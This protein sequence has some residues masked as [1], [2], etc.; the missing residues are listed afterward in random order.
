M[1]GR[2]AWAG[3]L[4]AGAAG[5]VW[6][7]RH[8]TGILTSRPVNEWTFT[9]LSHLLPSEPVPRAGV[10]R[11]LRAEPRGLAEVAYRHGGVRRTLA[12]LHRRT[13]TTGFAVLHRG[14][15]VHES[16][17]GRFASPRA[18]F[19]LFSVTKSVTSI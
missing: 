18:R 14:V 9:H 3:A 8:Q 1:R 15:L 2:V 19:Q 5:A 16:Y 10:P 4:A 11:P 12:D 17:P 13:F 6:L 7:W